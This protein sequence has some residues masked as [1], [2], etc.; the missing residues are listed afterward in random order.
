VVYATDSVG[1]ASEAEISGPASIKTPVE[2]DRH[3]AIYITDNEISR[4]VAGVY[5]SMRRSAGARARDL[6]LLLSQHGAGRLSQRVCKAGSGGDGG[7]IL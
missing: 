2:S 5:P 6:E 1:K 4:A 3:S 7:V